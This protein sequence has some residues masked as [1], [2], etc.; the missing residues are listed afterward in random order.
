MDGELMISDSVNSHWLA[1]SCDIL[2]IGSDR[3]GKCCG[4]RGGE[5]RAEYRGGGVGTA[6]GISL[7]LFLTMELEGE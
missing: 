7:S 2:M 1:S 6:G 5:L 3:L 4:F